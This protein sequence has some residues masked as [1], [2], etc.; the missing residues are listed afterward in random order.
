MSEEP[1]PSPPSPPPA[2]TAPVSPV[3]AVE[4]MMPSPVAG[5]AAGREP[6]VGAAI[7]ATALYVVLLMAM[8]VALT[9][10]AMVVHETPSLGSRLTGLAMVLAFGGIVSLLPL[11]LKIPLR[12]LLRLRMPGVSALAAGLLLS[13]GAW[14]WALE[15][16]V[17]TERL[18]PMPELVAKMFEKLFSTED[19]V[20]SFILIVVIPPVA[21]EVFCRGV[22]LRAMLARWNP[23]RAVLA[24]ALIFGAIHMN[25]WQFFYATWLGLVIGWTYVRTRSLGLCMLMHAVNNAASWVLIRVRPDLTMASTDSPPAAEHLPWPLLAGGVGLLAAGVV[26]MR[27]SPPA[28]R[29]G[30]ETGAISDPG[31]GSIDPA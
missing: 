14:V 3:M 12:D 11:L 31:S 16:G 15:I 25:P 18:L 17:V 24:S 9:V 8:Q 28:P 26:L 4:A 1:L 7:G 23:A 10:V 22:V 21:E 27:R 19:W 6:C 20:G 5:I 30:L 29:A 2:V 13:L